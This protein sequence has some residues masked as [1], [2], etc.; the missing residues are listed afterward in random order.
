[1]HAM[2]CMHNVENEG[3]KLG[4]R[5]FKEVCKRQDDGTMQ[6]SEF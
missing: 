4:R 5:R 3:G 6:M 1:M 2:N